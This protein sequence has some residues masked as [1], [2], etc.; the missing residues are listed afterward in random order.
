[1]Q[2]VER[3]P[4][5]YKGI[6]FTWD[7]ICWMNGFSK[8]TTY[9][10]PCLRLSPMDLFQEARW[11]FTE[12]QRVTWYKQVRAAVVKPLV[13]RFGILQDVCTSPAEN[14]ACDHAM[15]LRLDPDYA[16]EQGYDV[17]YA[18]GSKK[19]LL[20]DIFAMD[21]SDPCKICIEEN[22]DERVRQLKDDYVIPAF[23]TLTQQLR[24]FLFALEERD[25]VRAETLRYVELL[26][27]KTATI[28]TRVTRNDVED[29]YMYYTL[30]RLYAEGKSAYQELYR[31]IN[32]PMYRKFICH[33][34]G[35]ICP[36]ED[37][38]LEEASETLL[39]HS[40]N[41]FSTLVTFGAPFPFWSAPDGSGFLFGGTSPVGGSGIN[42]SAPLES[43][44]VYLDLDH[45]EDINQ[46]KPFFYDTTKEDGFVDPLGGDR[47]WASMVATN[48]VYAWFMAGETE[49][50]ARK[51]FFIRVLLALP[52][53]FSPWPCTCLTFL[54]VL[55]ALS[56]ACL[57][58]T[59]DAADE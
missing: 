22:I 49:M 12:E 47:M 5:T 50:I 58:Y 32:A 45:R 30:R 21:M 7:D 53:P 56:F 46:W 55:V 41:E 29:F 3:V 17:E 24:R 23:T 2:T 43:L 52:F 19:D 9:Q 34:E 38:T 57:L 14:T 31:E 15:K 44:A 42:M 37:V 59:S 13:F 8:E 25:S 48:P 40:D 27:K 36:P 11:Y 20:N 28:A 33:K 18:S 16:V 6:N 26:I 39:R 51:L 54:F 4:V 10:M 35:I 1:M